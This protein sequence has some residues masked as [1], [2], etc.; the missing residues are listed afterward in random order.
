MTSFAKRNLML[1][2]KDRSA[3]FF[4]LLA[5]LIIIGLY[6]VFLGDVWIEDLEAIKNAQFLM[7]SWLISGLMAVTSVTTTM[8]AFGVMVEDHAKKINKDFY[9]APL[10]KSGI[11][12][13]YILSAFLIGVIMSIVAFVISE[14]YVAANGGEF[15][16]FEAVLKV[17][18]LI[19]LT[20]M[21]NTSLVCFIVSFFKSQS[22]FSTASTIIGTLIG[23]LTGIYLPIGSLPES[24][25]LIIKVFPV[26]HAAALFRQTIMET[27]MNTA[28]AD[29]PAQYLNEFKESMGVVYHFG[30][31]TATPQFSIMILLGTAAV[32][33]LLALLNIS[34]KRV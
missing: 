4:S 31:S 21:A 6:A 25:Q 17:T 28:F 13:G 33:F 8:G 16:Q 27:P 23:F 5:V 22:A 10:K 29:I 18:G 24:V 34:R 11:T 9:A 19:F 12:G 32:F 15:L 20:G 30:N 1:F 14:L 3:V 26:S 2:F 7:N